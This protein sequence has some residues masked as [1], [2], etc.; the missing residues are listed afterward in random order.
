VSSDVDADASPEIG[1][2]VSRG[3]VSLR[4][5]VFTHVS[6]ALVRGVQLSSR[7]GFEV[8]PLAR[9]HAELEDGVLIAGVPRWYLRFAV[10]VRYSTF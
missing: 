6:A 9:T 8:A 4:L 5:G 7:L 1:H 10:G 2:A 3:D